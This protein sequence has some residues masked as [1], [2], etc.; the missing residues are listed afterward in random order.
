MNEQLFDELLSNVTEFFREPVSF[1]TPVVVKKTPHHLLFVCHGLQLSKGS[2]YIADGHG[3]WFELL[4]SQ[5]NSEYIISSLLQR[6]KLMIYEASLIAEY[7]NE[8]DLALVNKA[9]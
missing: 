2:V 4:P 3:D 7:D 6:I 9:S 8:L 5:A 1:D